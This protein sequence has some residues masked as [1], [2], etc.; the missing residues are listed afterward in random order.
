MGAFHCGRCSQRSCGG[1]A[2]AVHRVALKSG[3][4]GLPRQVPLALPH[5]PRSG[6]AVLS[7]IREVC[8]PRQYRPRRDPRAAGHLPQ[9]GADQA[10]Q[11]LLVAA[12]Q[13]GYNRYGR[14]R[15]SRGSDSVHRRR[16]RQQRGA[17]AGALLPSNDDFA[18]LR[19]GRRPVGNIQS[20]HRGSAVHIGNPDVQH[21]Y[22]FVAAAALFVGG[23]HYGHLS[24][25]GQHGDIFQQYSSL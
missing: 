2:Q 6:H 24:A 9:R 11:H 23:G 8:N 18:G 1:A 21:L 14:Q 7:A 19:C 15:G 20:P 25:D 22:E 3:V 13:L 10:P 5:H 17:G 4:G 16:D 12:R